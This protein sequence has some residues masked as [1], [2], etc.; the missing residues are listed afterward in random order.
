M[1]NCVSL[2]ATVG[3]HVVH[4]SPGPRVAV[5]HAVSSAPPQCLRSCSVGGFSGGVG[6]RLPSGSSV[7]VRR[8]PSS[9]RHVSRGV[10]P[11]PVHVHRRV[12]RR[13]GCFPRERS[14]V[15]LVVSPVL[16]VFHRSP[17]ASGSSLCHQGIS[18]FSPW[19]RGGGVLRQHHSPGVSQEAGGTWSSTLNMVAQSILR[20][21][22]G[23]QI[24]LPPQFIPGKLNALAD[25]ES[26]E[27]SHRLRVDPLLQSFHQLL[28][29]WPAT[30]DLFATF[31]NARLPVYFSPI[32]DPQSA[33]T[34]A[35][36][37]NWDGLQ[38]YAFPPFGFLS[39]VLAKIRRSR[40]LELTLVAPFW[41]QN[42]WLPD[43]LEL[44]VAVPFFLPRRDLLKQPHFHHYHQNL[45]VLQLTALRISS[46]PP[47]I[48]ASLQRW[49]VN[50]PSAVDDLR[51]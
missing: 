38:A 9:G 28:R 11:R 1:T 29:Q 18:S 10:S 26:P 4:V 17:R 22:E 20:L 5:T 14:P 16:L 45:P 41:P 23:F 47:D 40:G 2:T 49:L 24:H 13:L 43:L 8:F 34:D 35:M 27:P 3:C 48:P 15:Q 19:S 21:C 7:L 32:V 6:I 33:G 36:L 50:L 39:R 44:L 37:Q 30:I 46:N 25:S 51:G 12:G 31:L 42:P